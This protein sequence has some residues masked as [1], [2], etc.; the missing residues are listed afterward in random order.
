MERNW[1]APSVP[2]RKLPRACKSQPVSDQQFEERRRIAE[3]LVQALREAGYSCDLGD[4][5]DMGS[6]RM[7]RRD[8]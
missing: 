6:A 1:K 2:R 4:C 3:Q 7:L 5:R 8:D